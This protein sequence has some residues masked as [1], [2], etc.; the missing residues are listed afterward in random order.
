[1]VSAIV[2][3]EGVETNGTVLTGV[4][5]FTD[6]SGGEDEAPGAEVVGVGGE[7]S[8]DGTFASVDTADLL[9]GDSRFEPLDINKLT[10]D[11][12]PLSGN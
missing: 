5:E 9:S 4:R 3:S 6:E 10:E 12:S 8:S 1:M 2:T 11:A 7:T